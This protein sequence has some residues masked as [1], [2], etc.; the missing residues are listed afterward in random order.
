MVVYL[1]ICW[2]HARKSRRDGIAVNEW[3][4]FDETLR[5]RSCS[6]LRDSLGELFLSNRQMQNGASC[7]CMYKQSGDAA[8][9]YK[10]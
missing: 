2:F 10:I 4:D 6:F 9:L 3:D 5:N 8:M 7:V 1:F